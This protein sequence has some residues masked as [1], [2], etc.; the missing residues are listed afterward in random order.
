MMEEL[1]YTFDYYLFTYAIL[2][3]PF[4]RQNR[5]TNFIFSFCGENNLSVQ[6]KVL[7]II[8]FSKYHIQDILTDL[9]TDFFCCENP[10]LMFNMYLMNHV[11]NKNALDALPPSI[12]LQLKNHS[13]FKFLAFMKTDQLYK[14]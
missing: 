10:D 9:K 14:I 5:D 6:I 7:P 3:I 1:C 2:V 4:L 12:Y 13:K 11:C 8:V